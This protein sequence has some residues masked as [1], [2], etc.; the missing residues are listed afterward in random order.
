[1]QAAPGVYAIRTVGCTVYLLG[2][3]E[4]TLIDAGGPGSARRI[5]S[6]IRRL[7]HRPQDLA[8]IFLTHVD[9]DH[10][11][12]LAALVAATG[13]RVFAHPE[14]L[15]RLAAGD[16]P[17]GERGIRSSLVA[18]RRLFASAAAPP[19]GEALADGM[20]LNILGGLDVIFTAG[21][22][23]DHVAYFLRQSRLVL[24]GDLLIVQ[25][26]H[27]Q[28]QP[29]PTPEERA[30]TVLALRRLAAL[31]PLAVLP[32]HGLPYRNNIPLRLV[33]LAE[34]LEE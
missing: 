23:P 8:R 28:P 24:A 19:T 13:A 3:I 17:R 15:R 31:N 11:G 21:H 20:E 9:L 2:G 22:S 30:Q 1:M 26:R 6:V 10:V 29:G 5:L 16:I 33:R 14:A 27:L 12:G 4:L 18:L 7:E 25:R 34:I 32:A